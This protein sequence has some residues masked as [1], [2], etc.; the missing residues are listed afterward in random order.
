MKLPGHHQCPCIVEALLRISAATHPCCRDRSF[1]CGIGKDFILAIPAL[2]VGLRGQRTGRVIDEF[3]IAFVRWHLRLHLRLD[4][5]EHLIRSRGDH[6]HRPIA[7]ANRRSLGRRACEIATV[8]SGWGD[9]SLSLRHRGFE[10]PHRFFVRS[11]ANV[12]GA[13]IVIV[14]EDSGRFSIDINAAWPVCLRPE[15][16]HIL[17][18][19]R[20]LRLAQVRAD[21]A[22]IATRIQ[23]REH[24]FSIRP[25]PYS[26][27]ER[28]TLRRFLWRIWPTNQRC[29][30]PGR[31]E[32]LC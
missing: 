2:V 5:E 31:A 19:R 11:T 4:V 25:L 27:V 10:E 30:L 20:R 24:R 29:R 1:F 21:T 12:A 9:H 18:R 17:R 6:A 3:Q 22:P 13:H 15:S 23:C 7:H 28:N 32:L 26:H 16:P 8:E 14:G